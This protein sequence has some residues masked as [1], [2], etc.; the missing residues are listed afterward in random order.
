MP[1]V[2]LAGAAQDRK[3]RQIMMMQEL[4]NKSGVFSGPSELERVLEAQAEESRKLRDENRKTY[5]F[6]SR[7]D[8]QA[9]EHAEKIKEF[10]QVHGLRERQQNFN[11]WEST[12]RVK[13]EQE[14]GGREEKSLGLEERRTGVTERTGAAQVKHEE[15]G[16][17]AERAKTDAT[18]EWGRQQRLEAYKKMA[19]ETWNHGVQQYLSGN[20]Q[21]F[22]VGTDAGRANVEN[23]EAAGKVLNGENFQ[24]QRDN[25]TGQWTPDEKK[26]ALTIM[27]EKGEPSA[28]FIKTM[29]EADKPGTPFES[30]LKAMNQAIAE[31]DTFGQEMLVGR[32][33]KDI[34]PTLGEAEGGLVDDLAKNKDTEGAVRMIERIT[35]ARSKSK[36]SAIKADKIQ[37]EQNSLVNLYSTLGNTIDQFDKLVAQKKVPVGRLHVPFIKWLESIEVQDPEIA[38]FLG[39]QRQ[40]VSR[41]INEVTGKQSN[42]SER[43]DLKKAHPNENDNIKTFRHRM[44]DMQNNVLRTLRQNKGYWDSIAIDTPDLGVP[45]I[46]PSE[47]VKRWGPGGLIAVGDPKNLEYIDRGEFVSYEKGLPAYAAKVRAGE[48]K[49]G[50][51]NERRDKGDVKAT[52][53]TPT[54]PLADLS[55]DELMRMKGE[56]PAK[57]EKNALKKDAKRM[58]LDVERDARSAFPSAAYPGMAR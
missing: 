46:P 22:D 31:G 49:I 36:A 43:E 57:P 32:M 29:N 42:E 18:V 54:R 26:L 16:T 4:R 30:W 8:Q 37:Q 38:T 1:I 11:E 6:S 14:R 55:T 7:M 53:P 41:Y 50:G 34:L 58:R 17:A 44:R 25:Y 33:R 12:E 40:I 19:L 21:M 28:D 24:L 9:K 15:A 45:P 10:E 2:D 35:G 27:N 20:K 48:T 47:T 13:R 51:A 56:A 39:N 5:E 23:M 3:M 52:M